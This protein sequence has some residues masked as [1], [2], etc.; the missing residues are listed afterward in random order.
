MEL[1]LSFLGT[2]CS[3][4]TKN[5][6]LTGIVLSFLG[7]NY[8][9]DCPEG[10]QK[11]ALKAGISLMKIDAIFFSHFHADHFLGLPGLLATMNMFERD[12]ELKIFGPRG[13]KEMVGKALDIAF[14]KPCYE[15]NCIELK[16]GKALE[17]KDYRIEAFP[18][19]HGTPC[20]GFAFIEKDKLGE[21]DRKKA[22]E[23]GVPVG[24]LFAELQNGKSVKINGQTI[25]PEQVLDLEKGRK[26]RKI[27]IVLDTLPSEKYLEHIKGADLLVHEAVFLESEAE[28]ARETFH[29]TA[30]QAAR[31]AKKAGVKK[32]VLTHFSNRRM[33]L[34]EV[35]EEA[36]KE[37]ASSTASLELMQ[38]K[39]P[40][41]PL[42][43]V[44]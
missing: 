31:I 41:N 44:K 4:P 20:F 33:D 3:A 27:A 19:E 12:T 25:K 32:L 43:V 29:S 21:F 11:R 23:L 8:L 17:E 40:R 30:L 16:K 26:G 42:G 1:S 36:R 22:I 9:F 5:R 35:E 7:K 6:A 37:F 39:V 2:G 15:I 28:R 18:L 14:V 13:I 34:K 38:I 24:P 10:A